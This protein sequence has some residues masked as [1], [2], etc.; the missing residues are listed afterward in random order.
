MNLGTSLV[1]DSDEAL[2]AAVHPD[3]D[4]IGEDAVPPVPTTPGNID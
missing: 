1:T 4:Q 2:L 3:L